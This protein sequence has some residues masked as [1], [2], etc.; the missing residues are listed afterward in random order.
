MTPSGDQPE[1]IT[2]LVEGL[3]AG[4]RY[5]T[6]LGITGSGKSFTLANVIAKA[7]RPTIVLAPNKSLAAQLAAEFREFFPNNRVEYFVSYYDYYQPEAYLPAS[8]T[9]IEKDSSVNDDIYR[10]RHAATAALFTRCDVVIVASVSCIY[11][12]GSPS[13]Y[14]RMVLFLAVG[15][16]HPRQAIL[17]KLVA[18]QYQRNDVLLGRGKMRVRGDVIE[19][20]PANMESAYRIS[21]FGDEVESITHFDPLTGEVYARLEYLAV[22]PAT[23]YATE[24]DALERAIGSIQ[25]ELRERLGELEAQGKMLEA[26]R[27]RARTEYDVEMLREMGF[28]NGI[29]NYSR[30]LDGRSPGT[31]PHTLLDYFPKDFLII[32]DESHQTVPQIGGMYEGDRSR[33]QTLVDFGFRLPSALDNRPLRF[34]EFLERV[35]QL[36]FVSA[37]PS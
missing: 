26:H 8:D 32:I 19:V 5:Q 30:H 36:L 35:N 4:D 20:Q 25:E 14:E 9:Y 22:Y 31:A 27:L 34:D 17:E 21:M 16:E 2:S 1:A 15:E 37:T 18:I 12:M 7:Q 24:R 10:L 29:E 13:S 11:G 33:K 3:D 28:C 6:L 23:H